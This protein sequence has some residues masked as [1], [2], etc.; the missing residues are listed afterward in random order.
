MRTADR[1]DDSGS[2]AVRL[3]EWQRRAGRS[4]LPWQGT[5]DPY[6]IWLSE[7]MLQQTQ[8]ST[9]IP[10][11]LR[12]L[13]R[14]SD[15]DALAAAPL[16]DVL[17]AWSG[18]GYYSRARCL[19]RAARQVIEQHGGRFPD[20]FDAVLA[21][22]GIG[23]STAGAI[24]AFAFGQ[25]H[26]ILDGN[27]KRVLARHAGIEGWAG[28][29]AVLAALWAESTARLPPV[30]AGGAAGGVAGGHPDIGTYTQALMDLGAGPCA[31]SRPRCGECPVSA[32]C[33]AHVSGRTDAIPA[34]RPKREIP[35]RTSVV[36]LLVDREHGVLLERR[37]PSGIWG[38]LW[39][40]PESIDAQV[41]A[42]IR[43]SDAALQALAPIEHAFTHFRLRIEPMLVRMH[44]VE[45]QGP[46]VTAQAGEPGRRWVAFEQLEAVALPAPVR[47]LLEALRA[48]GQGVQPSLPGLR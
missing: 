47:T 39:S 15:V 3:V 32:D 14:F 10:Y 16:D 9:V 38:G 35:R 19:H 37:P 12:F 23:R 7:I 25:R 26:P 4:G 18:L 24:C 43:A 13:E 1:M 11:Y 5:R 28:E 17:A 46:A 8:V 2:F 45:G 41:E 36:W 29:P 22:P 27:V 40:L 34:P 6:R 48:G 44:L 33:T 21:L 42:R 31:R 20:D 30:V